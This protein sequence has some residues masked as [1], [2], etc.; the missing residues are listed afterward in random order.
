MWEQITEFPD[1]EVSYMGQIRNART[2]KVLT[3]S[4]NGQGVMKVVLTLNGRT[5]TRSVARIVAKTFNQEP[6]KGETIIYRDGDFT[7]LGAE[8]L[9]WK[10]RWFAQMKAAQDKRTKPLRTG[11]IRRDSTGEIFDNSLECA[12]AIGGI[13]RY[14][15]LCAGDPINSQYMDSSYSWVRVSIS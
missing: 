3:A 12:K 1:Y 10:P 14:I 9:E 13:E 5:Y 4:N 11:P 8:N 15:V 2:L 7:N 6:K